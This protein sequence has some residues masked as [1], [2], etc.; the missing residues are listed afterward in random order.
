MFSFKQVLLKKISTRALTNYFSRFSIYLYDNY[1]I[2]GLKNKILFYWVFS[3]YLP[4]QDMSFYLNV[5]I[6]T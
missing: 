5:F 3:T 6:M 2:V 4:E 1:C